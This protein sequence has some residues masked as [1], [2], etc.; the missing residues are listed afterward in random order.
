MR[1]QLTIIGIDHKAGKFHSRV[2]LLLKMIK[3]MAT[4]LKDGV[5]FLKYINSLFTFNY[6]GGP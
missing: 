4:P 1:L 3:L 5:F 6:G 2:Q